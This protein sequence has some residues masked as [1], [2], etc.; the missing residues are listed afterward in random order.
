[1]CDQLPF[2]SLQV[3]GFSTKS[4]FE[5]VVEIDLAVALNSHASEMKNNVDLV[6][7]FGAQ[8]ADG[9]LSGYLWGSAPPSGCFDA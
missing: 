1:V 2:F 6:A 8:G 9:L 7:P 4:S 5:P 3:V